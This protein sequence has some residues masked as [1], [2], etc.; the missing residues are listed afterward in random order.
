MKESRADL[1]PLL[2]P[3]PLYF[4]TSVYDAQPEATLCEWMDLPYCD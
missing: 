3:L 2:T 1:T 4:F